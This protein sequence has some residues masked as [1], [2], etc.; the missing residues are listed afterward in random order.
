MP[1]RR[2]ISAA[3]VS[4]YILSISGCAASVTPS[5][6]APLSAA[7]TGTTSAAP[8]SKSPGPSLSAAPAATPE[9]KEETLIEAIDH[10]RFADSITIDNPWLPFA[11]GTQWVLEGSATVDGERIKRRVVTTTTDLT[12][13]ID[14]IRT[15]VNYELDFDSGELVE[16]ELAFFA[17]A[18]DGTVWHLG[19]YP[20]EYED[21]KYVESP[22]WL[23]GSEEAKAGIT[24]QATPQLA[25]PSYS[26]GW[27]PKVG[28]TDRGRVFETGSETCVPA[29]C[30]KGVLVIDEFNRDEPDAHQL[31]YYASGVGNVRVGW[32]GAME[33]EQ[34]TL[35][36][37]K[38]VHL[39]PDALA[40]A[41]AAAIA[42]EKHAYVTSKDLYGLTEPAQQ[43]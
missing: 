10:G 1:A 18:D 37:I 19:Q 20:E 24:M 6:S 32:A 7:P 9:P 38:V 12:K 17:Q 11:P 14:G 41:R 28:W 4:L 2:M 27:G 43:R 15:V 8:T 33:E 13:V 35:E 30:Y 21:G 29:G 39:A 34:E 26:E 36:L 22:V 40:K 25:T 23:A 16:A 31:K 42:L 3:A 5:V